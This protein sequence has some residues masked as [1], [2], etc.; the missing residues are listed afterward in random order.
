MGAYHGQFWQETKGDKKLKLNFLSKNHPTGDPEG[1]LNFNTPKLWN[2]VIGSYLFFNLYPL[3]FLKIATWLIREVITIKG[4][5]T[6]DLNLHFVKCF[7]WVLI[8]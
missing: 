8:N 4:T 7:V 5:S 6:N 3:L 1:P 2:C